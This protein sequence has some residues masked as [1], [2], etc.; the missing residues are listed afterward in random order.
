MAIANTKSKAEQLK[1]IQVLLSTATNS[2]QRV[3]YEGMLSKLKSQ[4][5]EE[6][7]AK[8]L[9]QSEAKVKAKLEP[10]QQGIIQSKVAVQKE[11]QADDNRGR[12]ERRSLGFQSQGTSDQKVKNKGNKALE[13]ASK[14]IKDLALLNE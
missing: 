3:M 11:P 10:K 13:R 7:A 2:R 14:V 5:K 8:K 6:E 9:Q 4:I 1:Q 12:R